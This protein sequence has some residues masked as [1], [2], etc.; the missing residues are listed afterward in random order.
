MVRVATADDEAAAKSLARTA[1]E[2]LRHVYK[3]KESAATA[4][5]PGIRIVAETVRRI[6]GTVCYQVEAQKLHLRDLAVEACHR[7]AGVGRA[8]VEHCSSIAMSAGCR[9]LSLYTIR[10]TGNVAFFE[11]L[12]FR[13]VRE[14]PATWAVSPRGEGLVEVDLERGVF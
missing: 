5:S 2:E 6:V 12:G 8:L 3:P 4:S 14:Q 10:E 7:R 13:F 11:R 1:F 9:S